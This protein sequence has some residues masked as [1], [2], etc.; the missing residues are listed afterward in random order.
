VYIK[1]RPKVWYSIENSFEDKTYFWINF[2][3][4]LEAMKPQQCGLMFGR[5]LTV[6]SQ[7]HFSIYVGFEV[8]GC[9]SKHTLSPFILLIIF[10]SFECKSASGNCHITLCMFCVCGRACALE[11][12]VCVCMCVYVCF[13]SMTVFPI[14]LLSLPSAMYKN[15][16][17]PTPGQGTATSQSRV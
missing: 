17:I 3:V 14:L 10:H 4:L 12:C 7:C 1:A 13:W 16:D 8:N 11:V 2:R 6:I 15:R 5:S 9:Y